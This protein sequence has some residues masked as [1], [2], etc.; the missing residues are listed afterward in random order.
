MAVGDAADG[1]EAVDKEADEAAIRL[2]WRAQD[3]DW[4]VL[5]RQIEL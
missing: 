1:K 5:R 2:S 4:C 3:T